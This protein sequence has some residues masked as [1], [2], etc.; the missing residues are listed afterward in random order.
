MNDVGMQHPNIYSDA[1]SNAKEKKK[2]HGL[3]HEICV[4]LCVVYVVGMLLTDSW[5][6]GVCL[7]SSL[8]FFLFLLK[9]KYIL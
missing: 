4:C 6:G 9:I 5:R 2:E 7:C 8:F 1:A 3:I